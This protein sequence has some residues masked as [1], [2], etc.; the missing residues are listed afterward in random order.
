L[1]QLWATAA[2]FRN[3]CQRRY[4]RK[5]LSG[6]IGGYLRRGRNYNLLSAG[7]AV[8]QGNCSSCQLPTITLSETDRSFN[9]EGD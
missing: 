5:D 7:A 6:R 1:R 8:K 2:N 3:D 9:L 4:C